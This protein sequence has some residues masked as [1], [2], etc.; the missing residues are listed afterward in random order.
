MRVPSPLAVVSSNFGGGRLVELLF[1]Y[2]RRLRVWGRRPA[3]GADWGRTFVEAIL[4][5]RQPADARPLAVLMKPVP[6]E[7]REQR[8]SCW[9]VQSNPVLPD[10]AAAV[11]RAGFER[12][13]SGNA[14]DRLRP[15]LNRHQPFH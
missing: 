15:S 8:E 9:G 11:S 12:A 6:L 2:A 5:G 14:S 7:W 4:D 3:S 13:R 10:K 1:A